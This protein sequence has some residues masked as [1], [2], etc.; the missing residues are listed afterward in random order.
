[1]KNTM[2]K[3]FTLIELLVVMAII[4]IMVAFGISNL[5]GAKKAAYITAMKNDA[6]NAI[7]AT[8]GYYAVH[9]EYPAT[10]YH[11]YVDDGFDKYGE[12]KWDGFY[13]HAEDLKYALYKN[14]N[15]TAY[16]KIKLDPKDC[17][18]GMDG[19]ILEIK[20][21][22]VKDKYVHFDS[23]EDASPVVKER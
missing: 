5:F 10:W 23:C 2:R 4:S 17:D 18:N 3:G 14:E 12:R 20:N 11:D 15:H 7:A 19:Y 8:E 13:T 1:M 16:N 6:R 21:T 22:K 9:D